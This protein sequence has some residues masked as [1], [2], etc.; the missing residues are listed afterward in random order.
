MF[1]N[2]NNND[3]L[4]NLN[5]MFQIIINIKLFLYSENFNKST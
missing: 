3:F 4:I 1:N 5:L 2:Y